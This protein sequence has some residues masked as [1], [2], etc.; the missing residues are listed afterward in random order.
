MRS[1]ETVG[2]Q[3]QA[4]QEGLGEM[5]KSAADVGGLKKCWKC[6]KMREA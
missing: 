4:V 5:K 1:F 2:K 6:V 3:L